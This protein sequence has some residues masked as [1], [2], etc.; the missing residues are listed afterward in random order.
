[1]MYGRDGS[2]KTPQGFKVAATSYAKLEAVADDLRKL[3]PVMRGISPYHLDAGWILERTLPHAGY[4]YRSGDISKLGECAAFT[5]PEKG[6]VVL[7][8]DVYD[9]LEVDN[10]FSRSTVVHELSHIVLDHAVSL[11]RGG[12]A[13]DHKFYADSEWQ[14]KALTA[15]LMMPIEAAKIARNPR[16]LAAMCGTSVQ[17]AT[18]RIDRLT[19]DNLI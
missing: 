5:I 7:R 13:G 3:L 17:A 15:A 12:A 10:V 8:E 16:T 2:P 14:A 6:L 18:Y 1:M 19:K 9:G 4:N 11:Q